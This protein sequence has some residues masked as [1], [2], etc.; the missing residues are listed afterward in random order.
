MSIQIQERTLEVK[1]SDSTGTVIRAVAGKHWNRW[2]R[3]A[4][5]NVAKGA[6]TAAGTALFSFVVWWLQRR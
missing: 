3:S 2:G 1:S 5:A 4:V 6:S